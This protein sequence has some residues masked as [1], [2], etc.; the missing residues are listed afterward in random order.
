MYTKLDRLTELAKEDRKRQFYSIAHMITPE[1][2]YAAYRGLRKKASAGVDGVTYEMYERDAARNIQTLHERLKNGKYQAQPLRRVYIRKENGKQ[3][4]LSIPALEDKIVQKAMVEIL[5]AIYEQDFLGCSYGFRPGKGQHQALNEVGRV[6]CTRPTAW[7][8][9]LDITAYFDSIVRKQL[10]ELIEKRVRDGSVLRLIRK[11]IQAGVIEEGRLLVSETGTGQGQTI[12]PLLANIYLHYVLDEWFENE[13]KP[14]LRGEAHEIRFAD[15]AVL[16]FRYK[17]D[18]ERVMEVLPKRFA[19]YGL[20]LHPEKTRLLEFGRYAEEHAK[21]QGKKKPGTFDF[22]GL[23][24]ICAR[25]RKGKFAVHVRTMKKRFRRGLTA[26]AKWCQENRHAPVD[27]Q[28][29]TLNAK[30]R[31]H[32]QYYGRPTNYRKLRE[33]YQ[34]VCHIWRKWLSRRTRGNGMTWEKFTAILRRHPLLR[35]RIYHS[36]TGDASHA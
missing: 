19:K 20:T 17:E 22:L 9:E 8:V 16:S 28:Q 15:D 34:E 21:R 35:P 5:N 24:H 18:A 2:L 26:I 3:R 31:G 13:V 10:M 27:E 4:P 29:K 32:Y 30:L 25:S 1:A 7:I 23:T 6:V 36:W 33:F 11:W 14:R 12:S